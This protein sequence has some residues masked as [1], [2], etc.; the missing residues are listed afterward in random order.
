VLP[1]AVVKFN[2]RA[3]EELQEELEVGLEGVRLGQEAP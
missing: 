3:L 2:R 1:S